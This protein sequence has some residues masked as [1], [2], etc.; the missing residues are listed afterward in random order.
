MYKNMSKEVLNEVSNFI[1]RNFGLNFPE[2]RF[3]DLIRCLCNAAKQKKVELERY[4][5]LMISSELSNQDLEVLTTYLTIGE[6]YFFRDKKLFEIMKDKILPDII[7]KRKYSNK[8]LKIWSAGCSSGE[9]A[10]S[11]AIL[12]KELIPDYK[13]WDIKI[14]ATDINSNFLCKAKSGVYSEWSFRDVDLNIKNKYFK[15]TENS[16]YK[17]D[18]NIIKLVNFQRLNLVDK[19]YVIDKEILN[20]IDIIFCRNVLMYFSKSQV[21]EI[22]SRFYNSIINGGWL[23]L[24][25]T[26]SLF[27]NDTSFIPV[28]INDAFLYNKNINKSNPVKQFHIRNTEKNFLIQKEIMMDYTYVGHEKVIK[29]KNPVI[30]AVEDIKISPKLPLE[31]KVNIEEFEILARGLANERNFEEAIKWCKKAILMDKINPFYYYLLASINQEQGTISE[32]IIEL[33]KAIYLDSEFIMAYFDLGNLNLKQ[34]KHKEA[35]KN[36]EN[37]HTLLNNFSEEDIIPHSEQM[38]VGML[39]QMIEKIP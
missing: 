2:E 28:N 29:V 34:G 18:E 17:I 37:V 4:I 26:E 33:K 1:E 21:K 5:N 38:T 19:T 14:I 22:I 30:P 3:K 23:I 36:F 8:S 16:H 12:L 10:Y 15:I 35:I 25:P 27:I 9:E 24:A 39:K 31:D 6:T 7:N 11:I 20:N 32:A 13:D